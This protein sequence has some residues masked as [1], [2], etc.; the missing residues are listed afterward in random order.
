MRITETLAVAAPADTVWRVVTDLARYPEWNPFV[1]AC[2]STL[3]P[4]TPIAMRVRVLPFAAQPQRETIFE[5]EPGRRLRYGI[6]ATALGALASSR[7]HDV[8]ATGPETSR[9]VSTFA[10]DGWLAPVVERLL[11]GR[12]ARGFTAMSA[13]LKARAEALHGSRVR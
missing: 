1:V 5:H 10:L 13:A 7:A 3:E 4:G 8:E 11:G 12:L 6:A 9:Y 2:R